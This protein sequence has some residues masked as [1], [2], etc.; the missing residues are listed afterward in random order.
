MKVAVLHPAAGGSLASWFF[1]TRS[2]REYLYDDI[3]FYGHFSL[4][5]YIANFVATESVAS[6]VMDIEVLGEYLSMLSSS[7]TPEILNIV[8]SVLLK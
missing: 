5:K 8:A 6:D 2:A 3:E 1:V 4:L 7:K